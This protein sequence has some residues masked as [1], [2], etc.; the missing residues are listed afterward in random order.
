M[1]TVAFALGKEGVRSSCVAADVRTV[2]NVFELN[3][4]DFI[5][6]VMVMCSQIIYMRAKTKAAGGKKLG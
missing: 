3:A 4:T 6:G 5:S 1:V 2:G